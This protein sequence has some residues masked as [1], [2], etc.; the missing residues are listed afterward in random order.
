MRKISWLSTVA[1]MAAFSIFGTRA[2]NAS[3][4]SWKCTNDGDGAIN[5]VASNWE[6]PSPGLYDMTISGDQFWGPGDM[7]GTFTTDSS[8]DPALFITN[9]ID[10]DTAGA[11]TAYEA[12]VAMSSTFTLSLDSVT[13]PAGWS[14]TLLSPVTL[15]TN[16]SDANYGLYVG[17]I[18]MSG[19]P[20]IPVGGELDFQYLMSF[21]G[22]PNGSFSFHETLTPT[23][24]PE[25]T[26]LGLLVLGGIG[27]MTRRHRR[28]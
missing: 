6:N 19:T 3:I 9:A 21:A 24:V 1:A 13:A 28:N 5:C 10:N 8:G 26:S 11:W 16:P 20:T 25:P 14:V 17:S 2:A 23:L 15:D 27:M 12:D 7:S 18:F 22:T 4:V